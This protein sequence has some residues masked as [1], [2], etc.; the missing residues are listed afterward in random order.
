MQFRI[1]NVDFNKV[2]DL[3]QDPATT[4]YISHSF[5]LGGT[6]RQLVLMGCPPDDIK[7]AV[8]VM[9]E[10]SLQLKERKLNG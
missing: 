9:I 8:E 7:K 10:Q 5:V 6:I 4:S 3:S 1:E 2:A